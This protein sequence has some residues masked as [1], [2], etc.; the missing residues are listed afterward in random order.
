[1]EKDIQSFPLPDR[2]DFEHAA[3]Q[4][5]WLQKNGTKTTSIITTLGCPFDCDFCS[6]PV[7]GRLF[8]HR[9]LDA[10][11][12]EIEE[13]RKFGYDGLWIADDNFTLSLPYLEE[14]C[15]RIAGLKINW[16]CLS[17]STGIDGS[18]AR[19]MKAAG[20]QRVY[21]GLESGSQTTLNLMNKNATLEDGINAVHHFQKAGIQVAAFFIIGYPGET[22]SSIESTFNLALTLPLDDISFNVPYP[23][24]GSR[25]YDRVSGIDENKDW[26]VENEVTFI[27]SSEFDP[28]WLR[29]RIAQ[30]LQAFA[31]K[32][33]SPRLTS[34]D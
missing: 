4:K 13:I 20:C 25:L 29:R 34:A 12:K 22:V 8:R 28:H 26:V 11:F 9:N 19:H 17:R 31:D 24:P 10:V 6:R 5:V 23:L 21:I 27:Y 1:M 2:S 32:K 15:Q 18:L 30:T 14:F 7:F 16:S 3:Y 33:N